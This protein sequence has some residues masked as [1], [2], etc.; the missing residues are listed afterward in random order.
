[1]V[2]RVRCE[3]LA[4]IQHEEWQRRAT[5]KRL[6]A[7]AQPA[8]A[9]TSVRIRTGSILIAAGCRQQAPGAGRLQRQPDLV[10]APCA[11]IAR[12]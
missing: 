9:L 11:G 8:S 4:P 2:D 10:S 12:P 6:A 7:Q 5:R 1:M 3:L